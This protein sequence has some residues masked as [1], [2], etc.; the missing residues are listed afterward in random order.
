MRRTLILSIVLGALSACADEGAPEEATILRTVDEIEQYTSIEEM[1]LATDLLIEGEV[2]SI[3]PG[4][5]I[6]TPDHRHQMAVATVAVS[7]VYLHGDDIP[8]PPAEVAIEFPR[9]V[10]IAGHGRRRIVRADQGDQYEVGEAGVYA[11][12]LTRAGTFRTVSI[13][14]RIP[15]RDGQI[16]APEAAAQLA[17]GDPVHL[18]RR[19]ED[20]ARLAEDGSRAR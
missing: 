13:Q 7:K 8:A 19:I 18:R 15:I 6:A 5:V 12:R 10:D 16:L 3:D 14:G 11:L 20:A 9:Y 1:V 4:R 17:G 2:V